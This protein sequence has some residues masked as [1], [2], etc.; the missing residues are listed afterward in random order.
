[1][2]TDGPRARILE[3][4]G[5]IFA[6]KGFEA[7]TVREICQAAGVNLAAVNYYFGGKEQLYQ[8]A[9][10]HAHPRKSGPR[11]ELDWP[12][13]TPPEKKLRDFIHRLVEHLLGV[14]ASPWQERLFVRELLDPT[15]A[16]RE[17][18]REHF[19]VGFGQL[20]GI[21]DEILPADTPRHKRD[22]IGLSIIGQCVYYRSSRNILPLI[23]GE[24]E[25]QAY[26]GIDEL[27]EHIAHVSLAALGRA[28]PVGGPP[29]WPAGTIGTSPREPD[30]ATAAGSRRSDTET[31]S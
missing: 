14:H 27:A 10:A 15:P 13:G 21:L 29:G 5:P 20:Q 9:L 30:G 31:P 8:E 2:E 4:A 6:E 28:P 19:R 24:E 3:A 23:V 26:Y 16:F 22:Q 12:E 25:L 7:A 11:A 17:L 1:M 18:V